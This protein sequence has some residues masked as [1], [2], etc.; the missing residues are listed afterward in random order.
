M[1]MSKP[2][3]QPPSPQ[4]DPEENFLQ[5]ASLQ[6]L[7]EGLAAKEIITM[8]REDVR[9]WAVKGWNLTGDKLQAMLDE[10]A[11]FV[12]CQDETSSGV[13]VR[14][15]YEPIENL[16]KIFVAAAGLPTHT[17]WKAYV[18]HHIA[19]FDP[20]ISDGIECGWSWEQI[21]NIYRNARRIDAALVAGCPPDIPHEKLLE[22]LHQRNV[23]LRMEISILEGELKDA[24]ER[25]RQARQE[26]LNEMVG[27]PRDTPPDYSGP[28]VNQYVREYLAQMWERPTEDISDNDIQAFIDSYLGPEEE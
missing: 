21:M 19:C 6:S 16:R 18:E 28:V 8:C 25:A 2:S 26:E 7:F 22:V 4:A 11:Y 27:L 1:P 13:D 14:E 9:K 20:I 3:I 23:G 15:Y 10:W 12:L 24:R 5:P 17:S